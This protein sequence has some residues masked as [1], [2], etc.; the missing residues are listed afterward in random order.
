MMFAA[1]PIV[2]QRDRGWGAGI[3]GLPFC[4]VA[5]GMISAV[6]YT[7]PRISGISPSLLT[8]IRKLLK[9]CS[10]IRAAERTGGRAPPEQRLLP[11]M[12]GSVFLPLGLFW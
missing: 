3:G 7:I 4:G 9:I 10:F 11:V 8:K 6:I 5:V 12:V 1:F 2:F